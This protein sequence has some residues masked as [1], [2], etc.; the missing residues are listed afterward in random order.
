MNDQHLAALLKGLPGKGFCHPCLT[1]LMREPIDPICALTKRLTV[2][3]GFAMKFAACTGCDQERQVLGY[4]QRELLGYG[5][6]A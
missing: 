1:V 5:P 2:V 6:A 3:D 4:G